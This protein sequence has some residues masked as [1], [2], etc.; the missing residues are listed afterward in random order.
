M[1]EVFLQVRGLHTHF[2]TDEGVVKAVN[3]VDFSIARGRTVCLV[4]ESGCG[5]SVTARSILQI[6]DAPGRIVAGEILMTRGG[7]RSTSP[8]SIRGAT[9]SGRSAAKRSQ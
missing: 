4:G 7:T 9:R 2:F 3:G 5:K 1:N 8:G 6:V